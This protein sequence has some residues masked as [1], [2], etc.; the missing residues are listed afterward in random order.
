MKGMSLVSTLIMSVALLMLALFVLMT[1]NLRNVAR[2]FR[3]EIEI[4]VFMK[5][6]A[7]EDALQ[8][9]RQRLAAMEG[10]AAATYVS[11]DDALKEF[12]Q[13]LGPDSDLLDVL[14]ENPLPASMRLTM[15][16][17]YQDSDRL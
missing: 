2:S 4:D 12:R 5:E 8:G 17:S 9:F 14:Q 1:I 10:V 13:Q 6:G 16:E 3:S 7:S 11:K 15:K